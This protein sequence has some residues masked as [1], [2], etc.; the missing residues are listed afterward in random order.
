[1]AKIPLEDSFT[2]I[3]GKAQRGL[4]LSDDQLSQRA[5]VSSADLQSVKAGE[6]SEPVIRKVAAALGL[7]ANT[8]VDSAKKVWYP[9]SHDVAGLAQFN[10]PYDD[11][12]VNAYL[13]WDENSGQAV[14]FD[15]GATAGPILEFAKER[16]LRIT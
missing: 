4:K 3:I 11:M 10:T 1:M 5:G 2:D 9:R 14:A 6:V 12:T 15:T 13:A 8:L 7:G 16:K